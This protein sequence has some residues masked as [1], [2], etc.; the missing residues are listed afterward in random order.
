MIS[1][2]EMIKICDDQYVDSICWYT[3]VIKYACI[4]IYDS[5]GDNSS[6]TS[7]RE[8]WVK[9]M[10]ADVLDPWVAKPSAVIALAMQETKDFNSLR[11]LVV[12][13]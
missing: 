6:V 2:R 4:A 10:V 7:I 1:G 8:N 13:S 12:H 11:N 3:I 9:T 5:W